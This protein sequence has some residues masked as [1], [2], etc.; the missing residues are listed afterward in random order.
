MLILTQEE[1][2][3]IVCGCE[4]IINSC[5]LT[6][7]SEDLQYLSP[8]TPFL[9]LMDQSRS[10]VEDVDMID[11][12]YLQRKIRFCDKLLEHLQM[13]FRKEYLSQLDQKQ[14]N[15]KSSDI[16]SGNIVLVRDDFEKCINWPLAKII[17]LR[18]GSRQ[19][20]MDC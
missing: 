16:Q 20:G 4:R 17:E 14:K 6:Y 13:C 1:L 12:N 9:F 7:L 3:T 19:P 11:T 15:V 10:E 18:T 5:P 8:L 2:E